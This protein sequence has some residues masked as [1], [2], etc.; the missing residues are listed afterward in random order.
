MPAERL[1]ELPQRRW[2]ESRWTTTWPL[3]ARGWHTGVRRGPVVVLIHAG[4]VDSRQWDGLIPLLADDHTVFAPDRRGHG[5][6]EGYRH[7][8][9]LDTDIDDLVRLL[10]LTSDPAGPAVLVAHSA[11]GHIALGAAVRS[12]LAGIVI[13]YEP[14]AFGRPPVADDVW[15]QLDQATAAGDRRQLVAVLLNDVVGRSTGQRLPPPALDVLLASPFGRLLLDNALS[16]PTELRSYEAHQWNDDT[17]KQLTVPIRL[18][19]GE[20]SPP[21]NRMFADRLRGLA[22]NATIELLPGQDHGGPF[23]APAV[24]AA[25][26]RSI[27]AS[28]E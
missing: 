13:L 3:T 28:H 9:R 5:A 8:H 1:T 26:V 16:I 17:L 25:K 7:D 27:E 2:R 18:L 11:A 12:P 19:V 21:F 23:S 6:S 14:P 22:P 15:R 10:E 20:R 24:L 4:F